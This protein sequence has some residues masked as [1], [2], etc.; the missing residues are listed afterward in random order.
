MM[1]F[2][3]GLKRSDCGAP[4]ALRHQVSDAG[5]ALAI[6]EQDYAE[7]IGAIADRLPALRTL[8]YRGP[9]PNL[10]GFQPALLP[11]SA[12]LSDNAADQDIEFKPS[13]LALLAPSGGERFPRFSNRPARSG[14][15]SGA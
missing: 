9:A 2:R 6:A 8:V 13:D 10:S 7:R 12:I 4:C 5:A 3:L 15:A 11:W 14:G 1:A